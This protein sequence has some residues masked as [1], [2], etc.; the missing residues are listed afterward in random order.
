MSNT[1]LTRCYRCKELYPVRSAHACIDQIRA[2]QAAAEGRAPETSEEILGRLLDTPQA[3]RLGVA[4]DEILALAKEV[5]AAKGSLAK[6]EFSLFL[7]GKTL[8]G[9]TL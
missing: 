1:K 3:I 8:S 2:G 4:L 5:E 7:S 6:A 9:K